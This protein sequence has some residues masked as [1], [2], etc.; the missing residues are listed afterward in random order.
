MKLKNTHII[1][2][3]YKTDHINGS[4]YYP[5]FN[6]MRQFNQLLYMS[7]IYED[8]I[9]ELY[10]THKEHLDKYESVQSFW[11]AIW[12]DIKNL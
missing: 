6:R 3:F 12:Q 11:R 10:K 9:S 8:Q 4:I 5:V 7:Y 2:I 1:L